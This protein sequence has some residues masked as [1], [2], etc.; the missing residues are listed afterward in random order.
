MA[1][2]QYVQVIRW[3]GGKFQQGTENHETKLNISSI[4]EIFSTWN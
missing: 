3:Q 2:K 4:T 1:L